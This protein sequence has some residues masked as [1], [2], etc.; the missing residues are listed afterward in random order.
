MVK[1]LPATWE[2]QIQSLSWKDHLEKEIT[3][4]SRVL[5]WRSPW[6]E[7]PGELQSMMS[8]RVGHDWATNA[9]PQGKWK[10]QRKNMPSLLLPTYPVRYQPWISARPQLAS[11]CFQALSPLRSPCQGYPLDG[12]STSVPESQTKPT[13]LNPCCERNLPPTNAP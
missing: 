2:I 5:A 8:Q 11:S 9:N 7:K 6:T 4:Y 13:V 10:K 3:S 12:C 1:N